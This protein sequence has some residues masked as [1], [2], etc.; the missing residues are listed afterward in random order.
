MVA[1]FRCTYVYRYWLGKAVARG[2][3]W[4]VDLE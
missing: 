3:F 4:E 2:C 1:G